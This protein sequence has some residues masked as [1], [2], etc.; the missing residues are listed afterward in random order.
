MEL[1]FLTIA[2]TPEDL[3]PLRRLLASFERQ[4][5]VQLSLR[6]VGRERVWQSL[7]MDANDYEQNLS[8]VLKG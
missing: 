2:D 1:N 3:Q 8:A 6:R 5:Q 4:K 7:L